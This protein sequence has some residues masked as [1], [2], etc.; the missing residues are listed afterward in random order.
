[1]SKEETVERP[2][3][4]H[5]RLLARIADPDVSDDELVALLKLA[6]CT[7]SPSATKERATKELIHLLLRHAREEDSDGVGR[8]T[9]VGAAARI[10]LARQLVL[11]MPSVMGASEWHGINQVLKRC[12]NQVV[13]FYAE[14]RWTLSGNDADKK[15]VHTFLSNLWWFEM[16]TRAGYVPIGTIEQAMVMTDH[17][18][19]LRHHS[20]CTTI[21]LLFSAIR[22]IDGEQVWPRPSYDWSGWFHLPPTGLQGEYLILPHERE[23]IMRA[24]GKEEDLFHENV[25]HIMAMLGAKERNTPLADTL[26]FLLSRAVYFQYYVSRHGLQGLAINEQLH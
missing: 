14:H 1:M 21:P 6:R 11:L 12:V 26:R 24:M 22:A 19:M 20:V 13:A 4:T 16:K 23:D 5:E 8:P 15:V 18:E 3:M 17:V 9:K 25:R 2:R 10:Q 7:P